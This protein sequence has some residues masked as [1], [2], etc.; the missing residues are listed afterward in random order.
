M[1]MKFGAHWFIIIQKKNG[2][3]MTCEKWVEDM[4]YGF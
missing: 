1:W 3:E 2:L 4:C